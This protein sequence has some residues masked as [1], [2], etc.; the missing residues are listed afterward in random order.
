MQAS[1]QHADNNPRFL[2]NG[3]TIIELLIVVAILLLL[4]TFTAVAI[5]FTFQSERVGGA[6]RQVQS[7]LEGARDRAI[8]TGAPVGVRFL[9]DQDPDNGRLVSSM[10]Y[11][12]L[13]DEWNTGHITLKRPDFDD[14]GVVDD[15]D[16]D[17]DPDDRVLMVDGD[18]QTRWLSLYH[19]GFLGVYERDADND[20]VLDANEDSNGNGVF[21]RV[22]PRIKIPGN[23]NGT[24]YRVSTYWLG[25]STTT[26]NRLQLVQDYR[27]PGTTPSDEVVAFEGTGNS[28]Y[29]LELP[30]RVMPDA[31][32]VTFSDG[33]VIDLDASSVP[34]TWRP[35]SGVSSISTASDSYAQHRFPYSNRMDLMFSPRGTIIGD[36]AG[37]GVLHFY[38][39][40]RERRSAGGSIL[41]CQADEL[42][43]R[44]VTTSPVGVEQSMV[45]RPP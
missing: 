32:P 2:R 23:R 29:I 37:L 9:L 4:T 26:P 13:A 18:A 5:D 7:M 1:R 17:G 30:P 33:V 11:V 19:R 34:V 39:A 36:A 6:A 42:L 10:V 35:P 25:R 40:L 8:R 12:S 31:D 21:D 28:T 44:S 15:L 24:W 45:R 38:I 16:G 41:M 43:Q 3:F 22:T 20:G 27:D 14:D